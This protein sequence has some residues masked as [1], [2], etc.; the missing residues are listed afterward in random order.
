[1]QTNSDLKFIAPGKVEQAW[2]VSRSFLW[3][4]EKAGLIQPFY[5]YSRKLY[6]AGDVE[7]L[8]GMIE[9]GELR[10]ALRG[11]A[12]TKKGKATKARIPLLHQQPGD[13]HEPPTST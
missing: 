1:M 9:R 13:F 3:R 5:L 4:L 11:A 10:A 2:D 8:E 12:R 6:R 7:R